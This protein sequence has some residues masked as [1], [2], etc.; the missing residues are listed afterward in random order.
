MDAV[1]ES[2]L[3]SMLGQ[4]PDAGRVSV[5]RDAYLAEWNKGVQ[6]IPG[7]T[8][9]LAHLAERFTLSLVTNTHHADLVH[10]HLDSMGARPHFAAVIT[11]VEHGKRKPS[12]CIFER[13]LTLTGGTPET[14]VYIGDSF[15]ADYRGATGAGLRCLLID[16]GSQ[17]DVPEA[18]RLAQ[19]FEVPSRLERP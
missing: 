14:A 8:E 18:D 17:H 19:V 12:R 4:P 7:V 5:F 16:P 2:F 3:Q 13:A 10:Q 15:L 1:C 6:Y 11:S 9:L